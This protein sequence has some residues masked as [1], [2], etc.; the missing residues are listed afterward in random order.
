MI[1]KIGNTLYFC[2][3]N[4]ASA[5]SVAYP[6]YKWIH[7]LF[8]KTPKGTWKDTKHLRDFFEYCKIKLEIN[9]VDDWKRISRK[10][11]VQLGGRP[12]KILIIYPNSRKLSVHKQKKCKLLFTKSI[13][14]I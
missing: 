6:E 9:N 7:C 12:K 14:R 5:L 4:L 13:P 2:Y 10:Q 1:T 11:Y 8:N 3:P